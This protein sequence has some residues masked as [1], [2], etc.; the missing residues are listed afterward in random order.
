MNYAHRTLIAAMLLVPTLAYGEPM[1]D[2]CIVDA[3]ARLPSVPGLKV[4]KTDTN[5]NMIEKLRFHTVRFTVE[6]AGKTIKY[7]YICREDTT[8]VTIVRR[9]IVP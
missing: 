2:A 3:L 6:A 4:I 9:R 7:E 8:D 5:S 1:Q